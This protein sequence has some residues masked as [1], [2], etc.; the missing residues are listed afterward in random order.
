MASSPTSPTPPAVQVK[1]YSWRHNAIQNE[2]LY[3]KRREFVGSGK[4]TNHVSLLL[5]QQAPLVS[6][7]HLLSIV[8]KVEKSER[9]K[10]KVQQE[11][12]IKSPSHNRGKTMTS[13]SY[14][15][16]KSEGEDQQCSANT[17]RSKSET[18]QLVHIYQYKTNIYTLKHSGSRKE[19]RKI[20]F[21]RPGSANGQ[22]SDDVISDG[23]NQ[24]GDVNRPIARKRYATKEHSFSHT[25]KFLKAT[26]NICKQS[27]IQL[28][29]ILAVV[30]SL[31]GSGLNTNLLKLICT[32]GLAAVVCQECESGNNSNGTLPLLAINV[33]VYAILAILRES[34][35]VITNI[36]KVLGS[37]IQKVMV[38]DNK[39]QLTRC[40]EV[41]QNT[42]IC[43]VTI[44]PYY[45]ATR[46]TTTFPGNVSAGKHTNAYIFPSTDFF[47][48]WVDCFDTYTENLESKY[49]IMIFYNLV[50]LYI[51][52]FYLSWVSYDW[53]TPSIVIPY[54]LVYLSLKWIISVIR[55][56]D[57]C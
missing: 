1:Q 54:T 43:G 12:V 15:H 35:A 7:A 9:V 18:N 36:S 33:L 44:L 24:G 14:S 10:G 50:Y 29:V 48:S 31:I 26:L 55:I 37:C 5:P 13:L 38:F 53:A 23:I 27:F 21:K 20:K 32:A 19:Q 11:F 39:K 8:R 41:L 51:F 42:I 46:E 34:T 3:D 17:E 57:K 2:C 16:Q 56:H 4:Q 25:K 47:A 28:V 45:Y 40:M 6:Q 49:K 22:H 30:I 52:P